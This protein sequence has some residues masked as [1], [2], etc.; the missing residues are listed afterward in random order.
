MLVFLPDV[1][2]NARVTQK[3]KPIYIVPFLKLSETQT[4]QSSEKS[5]FIYFT[6]FMSGATENKQGFLFN[7]YLQ[8]PFKGS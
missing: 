5:L 8:C 7:F 6:V 4:K 1:N 2:A 3:W